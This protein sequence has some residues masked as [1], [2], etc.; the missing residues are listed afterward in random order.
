MAREAKGEPEPRTGTIETSAPDEPEVTAASATPEATADGADAADATDGAGGTAEPA[1]ESASPPVAGAGGMAP[2]SPPPAQAGW[3]EKRQ[4]GA[5][6]GVRLGWAALVLALAVLI[7]TV[8]VSPSTV[9]RIVPG[10]AKLYGRFGVAV[11]L[12]GLEFRNVSHR[13]AM[14]DGRPVIEVKGEIENVTSRRITVPSIVF[15]LH[16]GD[17][18]ELYHW[19]ART[20][21]RALGPGERAP[22]SAQIPSP[23]KVVRT[24]QVRFAKAR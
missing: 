16:D 9:V 8:V 10:A 23:P 4:R 12:R 24:L 19:A 6:R 21:A 11:N 5:S 14:R 13:W 15:V 18:L 7:T 20:S 22:F 3:D 1:G 17:G 2:L